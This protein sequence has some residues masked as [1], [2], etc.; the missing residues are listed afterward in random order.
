METTTETTW[1][2]GVDAPTDCTRLPETDRVLASD[3]VW[4][5]RNLSWMPVPAVLIDRTMEDIRH[6]YGQFTCAARPT[7][8]HGNLPP[9]EQGYLP[10]GPMEIPFADSRIYELG[11]GWVDNI[12]FPNTMAQHMPPPILA[13][14]RP[15]SPYLPPIPDGYE[16]VTERSPDEP[17]NTIMAL[18]N[19]AWS[20]VTGHYT[21]LAIGSRPAIRRTITIGDL[22]IVRLA[23]TETIQAGDLVFDRDGGWMPWVGP[24][25]TVST[26]LSNIYLAIARVEERFREEGYQLL[27]LDT[28]ITTG[29]EVL[30]KAPEGG[31][32]VVSGGERT[33]QPAWGWSTPAAELLGSIAYT[34]PEILALRQPAVRTPRRIPVAGWMSAQLI[35]MLENEP[36]AEVFRG[37]V[38]REHNLIIPR[39]LHAGGNSTMIREWLEEAF[40][41]RNPE[42]ATTQMVRVFSY[43]QSYQAAA[44]I[45]SVES[46]DTD[47]ED[48]RIR[49]H[50]EEY[51]ANSRSRI[52]SVTGFIWVP[53]E[54]VRNGDEAVRLWIGE[55]YNDVEITDRHEGEWHD[56]D[57]F[58]TSLETITRTNT[59]EAQD[60]MDTE[61][62]DETPDETF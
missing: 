60:Q 32:Y 6:S 61:E 57:D 51:V 56:R 1:P 36:S 7:Y 58:E 39:E 45:R 29:Q 10:V 47:E 43:R 33:F 5:N 21:M 26:Y 52:D 62:T 54:V 20:I 12:S 23:H 46:V 3:L 27:S 40:A 24:L 14:A 42:G 31:A 53:R 35:G 18:I 49:F 8:H 30:L 15:A 4:H 25:V 59:Q 9:V 34:H 28:V 16:L 13:A 55:R 11:R 37:L 2:A 38:R 17:L 22:P 50:A 41:A 44:R 48:V 19:G